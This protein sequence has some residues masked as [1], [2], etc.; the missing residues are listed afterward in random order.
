LVLADEHIGQGRH[1]IASQEIIHRW[2]ERREVLD[3]L[4][5]C[6]CKVRHSKEPHER[7]QHIGGYESLCPSF[8][9]AN[10]QIAHASRSRDCCPWL[11][12]CSA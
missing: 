6:A 10:A 3:A 12:A 2:R 4:R 5:G 7:G 1:D 9:S 11:V 8:I